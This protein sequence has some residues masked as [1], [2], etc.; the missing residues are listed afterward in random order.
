MGSTEICGPHAPTSALWTGL[1]PGNMP[2]VP[3]QMVEMKAEGLL[4]DHTRQAIKPQV[5]FL[6][7][8]DWGLHQ[9]NARLGDQNLTTLK[10]A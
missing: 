8:D 7:F 5:I 1:S 6:G 10:R 2:K 3:F 4:I 9:H